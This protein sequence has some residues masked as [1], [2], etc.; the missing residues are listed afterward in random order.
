MRTNSCA[1]FLARSFPVFHFCI[2]LQFAFKQGMFRW[3][4]SGF[5]GRVGQDK[6][7]LN[8]SQRNLCVY[9]LG[10]AFAYK[11]LTNTQSRRQ[12]GYLCLDTHGVFQAI[13]VELLILS[14]CPACALC[15]TYTYT[16][17]LLHTCPLFSSQ[18][19]LPEWTTSHLWGD[20]VPVAAPLLKQASHIAEGSGRQ[21]GDMVP[22]EVAAVGCKCN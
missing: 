10:M 14:P 15:Y 20:L 4:G 16:H 13:N 11:C 1:C 6:G 2:M 18:F 21:V 8:L 5:C 19:D 22:E 9:V 12:H 3:K 7:E 17:F